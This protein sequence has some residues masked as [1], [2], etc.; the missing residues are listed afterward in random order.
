M[1]FSSSVSPTTSIKF[2]LTRPAPLS[3]TTSFPV[4]IFVPA[5]VVLNYI[6][7]SVTIL[8]SVTI[9]SVPVTSCGQQ[10]KECCIEV[11]IVDV[12]H[13]MGTSTYIFNMP[14]QLKLRQQHII[15]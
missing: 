14:L 2:P 10:I 3:V 1:F 13:V 5:F 4:S 12:M 6:S 15:L 11:Q 9:I 8:V 7:V